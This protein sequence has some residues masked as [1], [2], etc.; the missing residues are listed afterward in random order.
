MKKIRI[1][2]HNCTR[3]KNKYCLPTVVLVVVIKLVVYV[4]WSFHILVNVLEKVA[5]VD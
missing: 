4:Y 1:M 3:K 5:D 2:Y